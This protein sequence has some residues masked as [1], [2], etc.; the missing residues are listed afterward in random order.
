[1]SRQQNRES[2]WGDDGVTMPHQLH[3]G[4]M[5]AH[6]QASENAH[7]GENALG[8]QRGWRTTHTVHLQSVEAQFV[9]RG[10]VL[11]LNPAIDD[12]KKC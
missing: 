10:R 11:L 12:N 1:M 2:P 6:V 9:G 7:V 8:A 4:D 5:L 3:S